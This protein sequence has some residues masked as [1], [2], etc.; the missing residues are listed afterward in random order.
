M[1]EGSDKCGSHLVR[2]MMAGWFTAFFGRKLV[3]IETKCIVRGDL[4]CQFRIKPRGSW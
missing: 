2:G 3:A 1:F 4:Y